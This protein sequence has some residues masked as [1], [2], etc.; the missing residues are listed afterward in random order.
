MEISRNVNHR[1]FSSSLL[2]IPV[3]EGS[4]KRVICKGAFLFLPPVLSLLFPLSLLPL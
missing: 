1:A 4:I 2:L 3:S